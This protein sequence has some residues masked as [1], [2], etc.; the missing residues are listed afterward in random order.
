MTHDFKP[1]LAMLGPLHEHLFR[2]W[3]CVSSPLAIIAACVV[4]PIFARL[5]LLDAPP[6]SKSSLG[7]LPNGAVDM[8]PT[9]SYLPPR[10]TALSPPHPPPLSL[11]GSADA[12]AFPPT[13]TRTSLCTG[14]CTDQDVSP[15]SQLNDHRDP[16]DSMPYPATLRT[17]SCVPSARG[18]WRV[19]AL[20]PLRCAR[21]DALSRG[22]FRATFGGGGC[23]CASAALFAALAQSVPETL[24]RL[25]A[26]AV[27]RVTAAARRAGLLFPTARVDLQPFLQRLPHRPSLDF[28]RST[29]TRQR[30]NAPLRP[31]PSVCPTGR[32]PSLQKRRLHFA[33]S[34]SPLT[35]RPPADDSPS[36]R[37]PTA[38]RPNARVPRRK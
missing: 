31:T 18:F 37:W 5:Q 17:P 25:P 16:S 10:A 33:V 28:P 12:T 20:P 6:R 4:V 35:A 2:S 36:L 30:S 13:R 32:T 23:C 14:K 21:V 24:S 1:Y 7:G 8:Q 22:G 26:G 27:V 34:H 11:F 38:D 19:W 15:T 29:G 3:S 9:G